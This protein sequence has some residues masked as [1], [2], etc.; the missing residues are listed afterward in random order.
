MAEP[1]EGQEVTQAPRPRRESRILTLGYTGASMSRIADL[2]LAEGAVLVDVRWMPFSRAPIWT[3][4]SFRDKLGEYP[5]QY[6]LPHMDQQARDEMPSTL[7]ERVGANP[8]FLA[9]AKQYGAISGRYL[10]VKEFGNK[11]YKGGPI[12]LADPAEAT[13]R[14][15][16]EVLGRSFKAVLMCACADHTQCHRTTAANELKSRLGL[17]FEHI[18]AQEIESDSAAL[19]R[20]QG[21][22]GRASVRL[23]RSDAD[24]VLGV[25]EGKDLRQFSMF[26]DD[27]TRNDPKD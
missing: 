1:V 17:E 22:F 6:L 3:K 19:K 18:P 8:V 20:K 27:R 16:Q 26:D 5:R 13:R 7:W 23:P 2:L 10:H 21:Q 4:G 25:F 12:L 14:I 15:Q 11:N 9:G 24:P